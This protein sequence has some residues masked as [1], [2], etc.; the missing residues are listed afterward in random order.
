M[1][2]EIQCLRQWAPSRGPPVRPAER[3]PAY[4][5]AG[6]LAHGGITGWAR[7]QGPP[8]AGQAPPA[9]G[10]P[11]APPGPGAPTVGGTL[12]LF[13]QRQLEFEHRLY[14]AGDPK[15]NSW[16]AKMNVWSTYVIA[17]EERDRRLRWD[18]SQEGGLWRASFRI[19]PRPDP[20]RREHW[21]REVAYTGGPFGTKR[22]AKEDACR[23]LLEEQRRLGRF[24]DLTTPTPLL[25]QVAHAP[26]QGV[27]AQPPPGGG[28]GQAGPVK[29][30]PQ[31]VVPIAKAP[32]P[33]VVPMPG[34]Q[35]NAPLH[36]PAASQDPGADRQPQEGG[37]EAPAEGQG[38]AGP[39]GTGL[40]AG[41]PGP[42]ELG[43]LTNRLLLSGA[44]S[45]S[46]PP[47]EQASSP[48]REQAEGDFCASDSH[49]PTDVEDDEGLRVALAR[50]RRPWRRRGWRRRCRSP[51][52]RS[53]RAAWPR[54]AAL[55][56]RG[57]SGVLTLTTPG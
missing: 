3:P 9:A 33:S 37:A 20:Q 15:G 45:P 40:A 49:S 16:S 23:F 28:A 42:D 57:G 21:E 4:P 53:R 13:Q 11:G 29:P 32:P 44:P 36:F 46:P 27:A 8:P 41:D 56:R 35:R 5:A 54:G 48:P 22:D 30:R 12:D 50:R 7:G 2:T 43:A 25:G 26:G 47:R 14:G 31:N 34:F 19:L 17:N 10:D 24:P 6:A 1:R 55:G 38:G 18:A 51:C 39:Y 52:R